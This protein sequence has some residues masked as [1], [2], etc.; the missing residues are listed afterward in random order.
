MLF[1]AGRNV[2]SQQR[3][4]NRPN[5]RSRAPH[6]QHLQSYR[7]HRRGKAQRSSG[8]TAAIE[9]KALQPL[10]VLCPPAHAILVPH[11]LPY[12]PLHQSIPGFLHP[13]VSS[14]DPYPRAAGRNV[15]PTSSKPHHS[16]PETAAKEKE[17]SL[18]KD[19]SVADAQI[20][21]LRRTPLRRFFGR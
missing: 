12:P 1:P 13:P 3:V 15:T 5:L 8:R 20:E 4:K 9:Q 11:T 21:Q 7:G 10:A 16:K 17:R 18:Q 19:Q 2:G 6:Q 14:V